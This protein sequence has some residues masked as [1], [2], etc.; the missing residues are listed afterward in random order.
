MIK[1]LKK[2]FIAD[3][4]IRHSS[5]V[6]ASSVCINFLSFVFWLIMVRQLSEVEFGI[7]NVLVSIVC[8][9][10]V[11][12]G[13][14]STVIT[15]YISKFMAHD[16]K[17]KVITLLVHFAKILTVFLAVFLIILIFGR[18]EMA[19]FLKLNESH[20]FIAIGVGLIF[21]VYA[22]LTVGALLGLQKFEQSSLNGIASGLA[23]F[24]FA[25]LFVYWGWKA[26][27]A[28]WGFVMGSV[29]SFL[30]S[31]FQIPSWLKNF[32]ELK[33]K[34]AL[35][36]KEIYAYFIPVA[37]YSLSFFSLT[38]IDIILVKH[39]FSPLDAGRFSIAQLVGKIVFFFP[40]AVGLVMFPKVVDAHAKN[41]DT[42]KIL[43]KC[44]LIVGALSGLTVFVC[45]F[46][47]EFILKL[48]TGKYQ[49]DL[50]SL[51]I[52]FALNAMA[53]ALVNIFSLYNLSI[54]KKTFTWILLVMAMFEA[55][56][57]CLFHET[58][59]SVL[60]V[61]LVTASI[62]LCLGLRSV[63]RVKL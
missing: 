29:V 8:F 34:V 3:S 4:L 27:G 40:G 43:K 47:P 14:L 12:I 18:F 41:D 15:R 20:Y 61:G 1:K 63:W 24:I 26:Y 49:P 60:I 55:V 58:L 38:N 53:F 62:L 21:S 36:Y 44:L 59:E 30:F 54:H 28:L 5:I 39:Y 19:R 16:K 2:M 23:K 42:R 11:P 7:L 57:I 51:V 46:F 52:L 35:E 13:V 56:G 45:S 25:L 17:D 33:E 32:R 10:S 50:D 48:L 31:I 9:F 6:F 37:V 22:A